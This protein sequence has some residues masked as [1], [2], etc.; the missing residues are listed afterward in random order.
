MK[1]FPAS[2]LL[3]LML[4][5]G[6][7]A[8]PEP[9]LRYEFEIP[10]SVQ[11]STGSGTLDLTTYTGTRQAPVAGNYVVTPPVQRAGGGSH[12][13]DFSATS[14]GFTA[15]TTNLSSTTALTSGLG[16]FTIAAW[17]LDFEPINDA[18]FFFLTGGSSHA[19]DFKVAL[20]GDRARL[21][22]SVA[23]SARANSAVDVSFAQNPDKWQFVAVSYDAATGQVSFYTGE[24]GGTLL[25]SSTT[26]L[27]GG[28]PYVLPTNSTSL[29]LGNSVGWDRRMSGYLD[30]LQ[31][32]GSVLSESDIQNLYSIPEP[33][34]W[35]AF[36]GIMLLL[37][38]FLVRFIKKNNH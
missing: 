6:L 4:P 25:S 7:S 31:F 23:G 28:T 5:L 33:S 8:Q 29:Y 21:G 18:R 35:G 19:I 34:T 37:V 36:G 27:N 22:L 2:L 30:D 17:V 10:G 11:S 16:S 3:F 14:T 38:V 20:S 12:A 1:I 24:E 32:Y 15:Q 9:V 13:L 26:I